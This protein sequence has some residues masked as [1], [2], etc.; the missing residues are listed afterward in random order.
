MGKRAEVHVNT[1]SDDIPGFTNV[2]ELGMSWARI[3]IGA[4]ET[5]TTD[6]TRLRFPE[7][8]DERFTTRQKFDLNDYLR[9]SLGV[10]KGGDDYAVV[11]DFDAWAGCRAARS[12]CA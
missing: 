3:T 2:A 1:P 8:T 11:L 6:L 12:G 9:G 4:S 5:G 10:F 7:L